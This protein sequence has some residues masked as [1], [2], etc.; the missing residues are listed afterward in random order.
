MN[1]LSDAYNDNDDS[2]HDDNDSLDCVPVDLAR[3]L[4]PQDEAGGRV[5]VGPGLEVL[6]RL[7]QHSVALNGP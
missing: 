4:V 2:D 3:L 6:I 7:G 1:T 5:P